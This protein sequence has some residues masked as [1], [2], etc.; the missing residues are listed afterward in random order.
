MTNAELN[1][2]A[3][4]RYNAAMEAWVEARATRV[5]SAFEAELHALDAARV[6]EVRIKVI[7]DVALEIGRAHV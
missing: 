4:K 2:D 7:A 6:R 3:L 1:T 5:T